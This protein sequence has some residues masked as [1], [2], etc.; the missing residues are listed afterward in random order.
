MNIGEKIKL[1]RQSKNMTLADLGEKVGVGKSTIRKWEE[2][3]ISNMGQDK[4]SKIA[5]ALNVTPSYL[6]GWERNP[7]TDN[8][9]NKEI[10]RRIRY[11]RKE[12]DMTMKELGEKVGLSEGNIQRYEAGKIKSIDINLLKKNCENSQLP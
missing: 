2:G 10:G 12:V 7:T 5:I 6:I 4:L 8:E 1:L 3:I 9:Y 11:A